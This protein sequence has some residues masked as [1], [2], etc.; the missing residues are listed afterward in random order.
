MISRN[1]Y[2]IWNIAKTGIVLNLGLC[3]IRNSVICNIWACAIP[4]LCEIRVAP[5]RDYAKSGSA[6]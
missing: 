4:D 3:D 1:V 6:S 5:T 2:D